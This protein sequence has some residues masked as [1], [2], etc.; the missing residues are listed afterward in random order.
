MVV[1]YG[2]LFAAVANMQTKGIR[3]MHVV[4]GKR[5]NEL[6][7]IVRFEVLNPCSRFGLLV[8]FWC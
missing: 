4:D 6:A 2:R 5:A 7:F 1:N 3:G 8:Y